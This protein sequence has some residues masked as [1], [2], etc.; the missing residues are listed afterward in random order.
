MVKYGTL[1]GNDGNITELAMK[2]FAEKI[3][4]LNTVDDTGVYS[5]F[6]SK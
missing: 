4:D 1:M 3:I 5:Y 6:P 2:L